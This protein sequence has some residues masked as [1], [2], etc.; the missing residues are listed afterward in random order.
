MLREGGSLA[1]AD[2]GIAK[3]L[4]M[5]ITDTAGHSE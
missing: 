1:L 4:L 3:H 5:F 2:F